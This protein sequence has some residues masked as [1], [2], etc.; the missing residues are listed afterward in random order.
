MT[1]YP[2]LVFDWLNTEERE[3]AENVWH[4]QQAG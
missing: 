1:G 4:A 3:I 2:V